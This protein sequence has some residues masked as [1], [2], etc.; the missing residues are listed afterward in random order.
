MGMA[1]AAHVRQDSDS[2]PERGA[3]SERLLRLSRSQR[4]RMPGAGHEKTAQVRKI[5]INTGD[6][7]IGLFDNVF[8]GCRNRAFLGMET[9]RR[10][11]DSLP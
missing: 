3:G 10:L 8:I 6:R 9:D 11:D 4:G 1:S 7:N 5:F 2:L